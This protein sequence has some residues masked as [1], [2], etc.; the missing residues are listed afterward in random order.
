M[1]YLGP[2]FC[3]TCLKFTKNCKCPERCE[4]CGLW[5]HHYNKNPDL[6]FECNHVGDYDKTTGL[7]RTL[8]KEE[9]DRRKALRPN[10]PKSEWKEIAD[11]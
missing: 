10:E 4:K 6:H 7:G 9:F 2:S 1:S 5:N 8:E 11:V 3:V